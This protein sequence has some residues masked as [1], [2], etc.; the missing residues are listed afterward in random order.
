MHSFLA[1]CQAD[2]ATVD[3]GKPDMTNELQKFEDDG[4]EQ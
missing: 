2:D 4:G 1:K 3:Y